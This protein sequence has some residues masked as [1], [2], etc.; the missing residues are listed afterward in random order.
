MNSFFCVVVSVH[1]IKTNWLLVHLD[2]LSSR[3]FRYINNSFMGRKKN[4]SPFIRL[5]RRHKFL[6]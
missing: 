2:G 6:H 4:I 3:M 1:L 5:Y